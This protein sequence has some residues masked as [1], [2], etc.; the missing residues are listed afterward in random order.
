M[1]TNRYPKCLDPGDT[2]GVIAPS[3][4]EQSS[5]LD[6]AVSMLE[7]R[8][9][10]VLLGKHYNA[11]HNP[12]SYLAGCDND[13][14]EDLHSLWQDDSVKAVFCLRGGYGALRMYPYIN[15]R[16]FTGIPKIFAGYSDITALHLVINNHCNKITLHSPMLV[17]L[18]KLTDES[19]IDT[20]WHLVEKKE[21]LGTLPADP[22]KMSTIVGG[23]VE[24]ELAG[25]NLCILAHSV[26]SR[27]SPNFRGKIVL[28]EEVGEPVYRVDRYLTQLLNAGILQEAAGFVVGFDTG[29]EQ[30]E[31][32]D[33]RYNPESIW[34]DR[35]APLGK[36]LITGF[37]FGHEPNPLTLPLGVVS[38]LDANER[39]LTLLEPAAC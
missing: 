26:G 38:R 17:S 8:G 33:T 16:L 5:S 13:K 11:V 1:S 9:Y 34:H 7:N 14:A 39:T 36:P 31:K 2:I 18:A 23:V 19:A 30:H 15:E 10:R 27:F 3:S 28:L 35:L 6:D 12:L 20:F 32:G 37:P 24:G 25:G 29:W 4:P 22:E 21:T